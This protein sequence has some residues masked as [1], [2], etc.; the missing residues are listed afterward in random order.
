MVFFSDISLTLCVERFVLLKKALKL[1]TV[2]Q[3][4]A[5]TSLFNRF[6]LTNKTKLQKT[7][8]QCMQHIS[9]TKAD[10]NLPRPQFFI[11]QSVCEMET[12]RHPAPPFFDS[13]LSQ[14][15]VRFLLPGPHSVL[16]TL[17]DDHR[18]Q[19]PSTGAAGIKNELFISIFNV[20]PNGLQG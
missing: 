11:K 4:T 15:R 7:T 10:V 13:G 1:S 18:P 17:Q 16:H 9:L 8:E 19:C 20:K 2:Q 6:L 14:F 3:P 5:T 12:P